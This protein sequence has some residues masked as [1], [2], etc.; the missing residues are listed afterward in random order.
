MKTTALLSKSTP[1]PRARNAWQLGALLVLGVAVA[2]GARAQTSGTPLRTQTVVQGLDS[3][4]SLAFLP[5]GRMLVTER[6][7]RLRLVARDGTLSAPISGLPPVVARGQG[8][9]LDVALHPDYANNGLIYWSYAEPAD[10]GQPG[11]ST[12]VAR[13]RLDTATLALSEV[14]RV[15]R[16][17]PK[18]ASNHHFGSRLVFG[19]DGHLFITLGDRASRADDA[20]T[21]DTHHGK[22]VRIKA[23]GGVP[24]DNPFVKQAG[25][26][27]EIWSVGHRNLQGAALH[28]QTGELWVHEHGPQ[29]GDELNIARAGRNHGWPVITQGRQYV[30]GLKIGE[31]SERA[32]VAKALT[33]WVPSI[34][35]SGMAF[36][37]GER[38]PAW[39]GQLLVGALKA[40][41]LVRLELDGNQVVR[42]HRHAVGARVRDVRQA[43]DGRLYL[44]TDEEGRS[45]VLRIE[46]G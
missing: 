40:E 35:P 24:A 3:P 8:G 14:Q 17:S 38:H 31:G 41:Q 5:D 11:N 20:Q 37:S 9:L 10:A 46:P 34:A 44:L 32:D 27:P 22:V 4:W 39:T 2:L 13:G 21:L 28:P 12:A 6:A 26:L 33:T 36:V 15:F 1:R 25:A 18:V 42:E 45:R 29:G 16:Q 19:R 30:S 23:D 7:G 43:P